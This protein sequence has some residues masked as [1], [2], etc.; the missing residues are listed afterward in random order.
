MDIEAPPGTEQFDEVGKI[1]QGTTLTKVV[2]FSD[3]K[4]WASAHG[5]LLEYKKAHKETCSECDGT[6]IITCDYDHEHDCDDCDGN[7]TIPIEDGW[8]EVD[9]DNFKSKHMLGVIANGMVIDRRQ[10][11]TCL[12]LLNDDG[13][14]EIRTSSPL[15]AIVIV[16]NG[17]KCA[18]M[19][20]RAESLVDIDVFKG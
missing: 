17:W 19:P 4:G 8:Q 13:M 14:C 18:I 11:A 7:G 1:F 16:G 15:S 9:D 2:S 10:L 20:F 5:W 3:L 6:G 12:R